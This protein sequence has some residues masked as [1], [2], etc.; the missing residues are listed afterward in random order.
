MKKSFKL[1]TFFNFLFFVALICLTYYIIFRGQ[2]INAIRSI[3]H[4][5]NKLYLS[6]GLILMVCYF[7]MEAFN[8]KKLLEVLGNKISIFK[9]LKYTFIGYFF[10]S[11]TPA[12]SGGQPV[13]IYYMTKEKVSGA[14][15]TLALLIHLCSFQIVTIVTG[16]ICT[17][18]NYDM[19]KDGF[20][21]LFIVGTSLNFIALLVMMVCI[22]SRRLAEMFINGIFT[23]FEA[24]KIKRFD[25]K[26]ESIIVSLDRYHEGSIFIKEHKIEFVKSILRVILQVIFYY[27]VPFFV[28]KSLGLNGYTLIDMFTI[29]AVLFVSV[30]SIPLPGAIG[31]SESAFLNIYRTIYGELLLSGAVLLSRLLSFY[32]FVILS[33]IVVVFNVIK[34]MKK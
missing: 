8:V 24:L 19:L 30:S 20:I 11:I 29:Q 12:A 34:H 3:L 2:D 14:K 1:R 6:L 27:S 33:L 31:I 23:I 17:I 32:I 16:I 15:A 22:F 18:I 9:S 7:Y 25:G 10:S 21:Y 13:E 5:S 4:D 26:K 28:Y